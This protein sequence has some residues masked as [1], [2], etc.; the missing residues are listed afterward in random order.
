MLNQYSIAYQRDPSVR[1]APEMLRDL[2][3]LVVEGPAAQRAAI[4]I[5]HTYGREAL[6]A[7]DRTIGQ[8]GGNGPALARMSALRAAIIGS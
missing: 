8:L 3:K 2:I 7:I 5:R 1:G 6:S 4:Q